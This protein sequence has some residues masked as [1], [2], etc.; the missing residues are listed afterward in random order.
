MPVSSIS[1][2]ICSQGITPTMH[3]LLQNVL[4]G[5]VDTDCQHNGTCVN[6][7][8]ESPPICSC[9]F[10]FALDATCT[11]SRTS[12]E[13][14]SSL[15]QIQNGT[16]HFPHTFVQ[17]IGCSKPVCSSGGQ[18]QVHLGPAKMATPV[19]SEKGSPLWTNRGKEKGN[20]NL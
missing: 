13:T 2:V 20:Q 17:K 16:R 6:L 14:D 10:D 15:T 4:G 18:Q 3:C 1:T 8:P 7:G 11:A 5:C 9:P 19:L 12:V